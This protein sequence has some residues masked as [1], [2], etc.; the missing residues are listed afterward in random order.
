LH[1]FKGG[2]DFEKLPS[3]FYTE[4]D[5]REA[6]FKAL[7]ELQ[8]N[9]P[10]KIYVG[11]NGQPIVTDTLRDAALD[12]VKQDLDQYKITSVETA[13][14]LG[15]EITT[16]KLTQLEKNN[17]LIDAKLAELNYD[18]EKRLKM[19]GAL[20]NYFEGL[21]KSKIENSLNIAAR[22]PQIDKEGEIS[23]ALTGVLGA[24][25]VTIE[26][27][28]GVK[29]QVDVYVPGVEEP[30]EIFLRDKDA[31]GIAQEIIGAL[32]NLEAK[33]LDEIYEKRVPKTQKSTATPAPTTSETTPT[34]TETITVEEDIKNVPPFFEWRQQEGNQNKTIKEY[35]EFFK[36]N[37][38]Q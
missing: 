7:D 22:N 29:Q 23:R 8:K 37:P 17:E 34:P 33:T 5:T 14:F 11:T 21:T 24:F 35:F 32:F 27:S 12:F 16:A 25:G 38:Q 10:N 31:E 15:K 6:Q 30:V 26:Q 20:N 36:I 9:N 28:G 19:A 13:P 2:Y 4:N 3:S 18:N 1:D